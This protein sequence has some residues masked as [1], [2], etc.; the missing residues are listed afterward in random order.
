M[1]QWLR[2]LVLNPESAFIVFLFL[3]IYFSKI[4]LSNNFYLCGKSCLFGLETLS[5]Q[6]LIP[7]FLLH[8]VTNILPGTEPVQVL[9]KSFSYMKLPPTAVQFNLL[10]GMFT[11]LKKQF[12]Q[13]NKCLLFITSFIQTMSKFL[14]LQTFEITL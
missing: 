6:Q 10:R 9:K 1:W 5:F 11:L 4:N 2:P 7:F 8:Y 14:Q 13:K 12:L 3:N